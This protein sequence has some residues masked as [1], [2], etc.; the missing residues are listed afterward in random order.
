MYFELLT[1]TQRLI[2]FYGIGALSIVQEVAFQDTDLN[3]GSLVSLLARIV[4]RKCDSTE[5]NLM[6]NSTGMNMKAAKALSQ[7]LKRGKK[8]AEQPTNLLNQNRLSN[9]LVESDPYTLQVYLQS[10]L[11]YL[12]ALTG[13]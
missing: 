9:Y 5:V 6:D 1:F 4:V 3:V 11:S 2:D 10:C 13:T 12:K 8:G 7:Q